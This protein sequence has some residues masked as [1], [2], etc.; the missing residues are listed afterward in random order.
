MLSQ[1]DMRIAN[2]QLKE[3]AKQVL[4]DDTF[5][6]L[7]PNIA[8]P[9]G[10]A[11][12]DREIAK[13][14]YLA[15]LLRYEPSRDRTTT[16]L[17]LFERFFAAQEFQPIYYLEKR[18][19]DLLRKTRLPA[20]LD[21]KQ[22]LPKSGMILFPEGNF[23]SPSGE[24][25]NYVLYRIF[26]TKTADS[27]ASPT[28]AFENGLSGKFIWRMSEPVRWKHAIDIKYGGIAWVAVAHNGSA[29]YDGQL[30][31]DD[32]GTLREDQ[33][34][35]GE[36]PPDDHEQYPLQIDISSETELIESISNLL[37]NLLLFC[38]QPNAITESYPRTWKP[39]KA[40]KLGLQAPHLI[41]MPQGEGEDGYSRPLPV[42]KSHSGRSPRTHWRMGHWRRQACGEKQ[43]DRKYIWIEPTLVA[44]ERSSSVIGQ[45]I[46]DGQF[47]AIA[48]LQ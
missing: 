13:F 38:E 30:L 2:K 45:S 48:H 25:I 23:V 22:V 44:S 7:I 17:S 47:D 4:D 37:G 46:K 16:L 18:L 3:K 27:P 15:C 31:F 39:K 36:A 33:E 41:T 12:Y 20:R 29:V 5:R 43:R 14:L 8:K 34:Y 26:D 11:A 32:S 28:I 42:G 19:F 40:E 6:S 10:Y 21:L 9:N 35:F 24:I 1:A